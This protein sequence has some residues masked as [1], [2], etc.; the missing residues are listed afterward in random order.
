[1][2]ISGCTTS[3]SLSCIPSKFA[4]RHN[5][6]LNHDAFANGAVVDASGTVLE[7]RGCSWVRGAIYPRFSIYFNSPSSRWHLPKHYIA[8]KV[9][10]LAQGK[11][12]CFESCRWN[13]NSLWWSSAPHGAVGRLQ[14]LRLPLAKTIS[15]ESSDETTLLGR[16]PTAAAASGFLGAS[17]LARLPVAPQPPCR[18]HL[19]YKN[20]WN[21]QTEGY[22]CFLVKKQV[23]DAGYI[24]KPLELLRKLKLVLFSQE[25]SFEA[26]RPWTVNMGW[27]KT[28]CSFVGNNL[29]ENL[30]NAKNKWFSNFQSVKSEAKPR[31]WSG[32][33][34]PSL[35]SSVAG[36]W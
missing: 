4:L 24:I 14:I 5:L 21:T 10:T 3:P 1:M 2:V 26:V 25:H 8:I 28:F 9:E 33:S 22:L 34:S 11:A 32:L 27:V 17:K 30:Q 15:C 13:F 6:P 19:S 12:F 7:A 29:C 31:C 36:L 16:A 20:V 23:E 18:Q 35:Q